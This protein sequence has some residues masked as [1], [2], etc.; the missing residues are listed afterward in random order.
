VKVEKRDL[1]ADPH[2]ILSRWK[3][4]FSQLLNVHNS[5]TLGRQYQIEPLV[6]S[7][8]HTEIE[9]AFAKLEKYKSP[10]SGQILPGLIQGGETLLPAIHKLIF[11]NKEGFFEQGRSLLFYQS[12][13]KGDKTGCNNYRGISQLS[14]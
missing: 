6:P 12:P 11:F 13:K 5:V 14:T 3:N 9:I 2:N 1:L 8:S 4:Y 10:G 7:P